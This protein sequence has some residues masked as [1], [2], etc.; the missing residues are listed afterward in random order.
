MT[1]V[2]F[3]ENLF[4][5]EHVSDKNKLLNVEN[6]IHSTLLHYNI[7][8]SFLQTSKCIWLNRFIIVANS[9]IKQHNE[10]AAI[11]HHSKE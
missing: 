11:T 6:T 5:P 4:S 2:F 10:E 3:K 1:I 9:P 8:A 7:K